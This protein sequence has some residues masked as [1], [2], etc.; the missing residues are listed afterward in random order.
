MGGNQGARRAGGPGSDRGRGSPVVRGVASLAASQG[1]GPDARSDGR[2]TGSESGGGVQDGAANGIVRRHATQ[3]HRGDGRRVG[4]GGA[5]RGRRRSADSVVGGS[6]RL[7]LDSDERDTE[8][9]KPL[10]SVLIWVIRT[11]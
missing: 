3:V 5:F 9:N 1:Q 2:L 10:G 4:A 6:G 7:R 11:L 8:Q